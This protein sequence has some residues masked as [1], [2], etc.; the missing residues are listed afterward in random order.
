MQLV[1]QKSVHAHLPGEHH[2]IMPGCLKALQYYFAIRGMLDK[3]ITTVGLQWH[4]GLLDCCD[5]L[6]RE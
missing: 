6:R 1:Q 3:A 2:R 5:L 4:F